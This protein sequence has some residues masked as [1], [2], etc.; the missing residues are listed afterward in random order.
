MLKLITLNIRILV[1]FGVILSFHH[2]LYA[3]QTIIKGIVKDDSGEP[4]PYANIYIEQ[5]TVGT[6]TSTLGEYLLKT[7]L[8]GRYRLRCSFVGFESQVREININ[9]SEDY[10]IDFSLKPLPTKLTEVTIAADK[11]KSWSKEL[12]NFEKHFLGSSKMAKDCEILNPYVIDF[13]RLNKNVLQAFASEPLN[14][15]NRSTGYNII[16]ELK[17]FEVNTKSEKIKYDGNIHFKELASDD[18]KEEKKWK[19]NRDLVYHGSLAHFLRSLASENLKKEGFLVYN[20]N[21]P[22]SKLNLIKIS[23]TTKV[24]EGELIKDVDDNT[25]SLKFNGFLRVEYIKKQDYEYQNNRLYNF[26]E[27]SWIKTVKSDVKLNRAGLFIDPYSVE[28][29]RSFGD[30]RIADALPINYKPN[31]QSYSSIVPNNPTNT[32][33]HNLLEYDSLFPKEKVFLSFPEKTKFAPGETVT[34]DAYVSAGP[35]HE[36]S[37]LS[38]V[39]FVELINSDCQLL[40]YSKVQLINGLGQGHLIMPDT[41]YSGHYRIRAY[42]SW[43]KNFDSHYFYSQNLTIGEVKEVFP[44]YL[45]FIPSSGQLNENVNNSLAIKAFSSEGIPSKAYVRIFDESQDLVADISIDSTGL[46]V[47][48]KFKPK[49]T[50][51]Y[52]ALI[53]GSSRRWYLPES[54]KDIGIKLSIG[55]DNAYFKIELSNNSKQSLSLYLAIQSYGIIHYL[56]EVELGAKKETIPISKY[57]LGYGM[58]Q[59]SLLDLEF[60]HLSDQFIFNDSNQPNDTLES[61]YFNES[62]LDYIFV[63]SELKN[64]AGA[65]V[66]WNGSHN[67][68]SFITHN[69]W[70]KIDFGKIYKRSYLDMEQFPIETGFS[71]N[72]ILENGLKEKI[73]GGKLQLLVKSDIPQFQ[74]S[75][76]AEDGS[77]TFTDIL[78]NDTTELVFSY[79]NESFDGKINIEFKD[80]AYEF[81][82]DE[83]ILCSGIVENIF[84]SNEDL[85]NQFLGSRVLEPVKVEARRVEEKNDLRKNKLYAEPDWSVSFEDDER[86]EQTLVAAN[87]EGG[88]LEYLA[89]RVSG[90]RVARDPTGQIGA[91]RLRGGKNSIL[92]ESSALIIYEGVSMSAQQ[93]NQLPPYI[94]GKIDVL[95]A[96]NGAAIYGA[97]G[98]NGVIVAYAPIYQYNDE[99]G[100]VVSYTLKSGFNVATKK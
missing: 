84:Y 52:Y 39:L 53:N 67:S 15:E 28:L 29:Y 9:R 18:I 51:R 54:K 96:A 71:I 68:K 8:E 48:N 5:S 59:I 55:Q 45:K 98:S 69:E 33:Y 76:V 36:M 46:G 7:D 77:F 73:G 86:I 100:K 24:E 72:G 47:I 3:Q 97:R 95:Q 94:I 56:K 13:K 34:F 78:Y 49:P 65:S 91:V 26:N 93:F 4:L 90:I 1:C 6:E 21:I 81:I 31:E 82:K 19:Q 64:S 37:E 44:S 58:N 30:N 92:S 57:L 88:I 61:P 20:E 66:K 23:D 87:I 43:M 12:K 16:Y 63:R 75:E 42:T 2:T 35:H 85:E 32:L 25:L 89:A 17:S 70:D 11:D 79:V 22:E 62:M 80:P 83:T 40:T 10:T 38:K 27:T 99:N 50:S 41:L 60:N 74:E 14:I